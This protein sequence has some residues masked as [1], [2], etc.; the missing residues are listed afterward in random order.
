LILYHGSNIEIREIDLEQCKPFK[1]FGRGFYLTDIKEQAEKMAQRVA[2]L[3]GGKPFISE[4]RLNTELFD[5]TDVTKLIFDKPSR[6]WALFVINNRDRNYVDLGDKNCNQDNKYAVVQGPV[7][8]D[9]IAYLFRY[10]AGGLIDIEALTRSLEY[11]EL[12]SQYSFHTPKAISYLSFT[13]AYN[14]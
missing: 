10:F 4:F 5:D 11:K 1:D 8:N 9:N 13:G 7:A 12:T 6:E 2:K 14:G 3:Y